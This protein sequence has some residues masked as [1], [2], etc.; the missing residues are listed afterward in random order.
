[1]QDEK[2]RLSNAL[3]LSFILIALPWLVKVAEISFSVSFARFGVLPLKTAGL[4]GILFSPLIHGDLA[5]LS[6]NSAPLFLLAAALFYFYRKYSFQILAT[7]WLLTGVFVWLF[8]RGNSYHIGASGVVYALATFHFVSGIIRREPRLMA[9]SLLVTFL[10]GSLVWGIFPEFFPEKNISWE[11]HLM[12]IVTGLILAYAFR[13]N[14]PQAK[15][16]EWP[17]DEDDDAGDELP[18]N[19]PEQTE[20]VRGE[21]EQQSGSTTRETTS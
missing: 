11:S 5:H 13:N 6:A 12:G 16:Y 7:S 2:K 8:A 14:G 15:R 10:Y 3:V 21:N 20:K 19:Q 18:W 17:E 9:F 4:P 1:M